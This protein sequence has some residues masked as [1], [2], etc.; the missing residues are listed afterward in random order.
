MLLL[1]LS[2]LPL[3]ISSISIGAKAGNGVVKRFDLLS[4]SMNLKSIYELIA[5]SQY[6]EYDVDGALFTEVSSK[7][8][9]FGRS[10]VESQLK[11]IQRL[12]L[13]LDRSDGRSGYI[14]KYSF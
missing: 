2:F 6:G 5:T 7:L 1:F 13:Q 11:S 4:P 9:V 10:E 12:Q 8:S 3:L 14:F